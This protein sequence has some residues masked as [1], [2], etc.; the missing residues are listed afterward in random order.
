MFIIAILNW[1]YITKIKSLC[2]NNLEILFFIKFLK[3]NLKSQEY[4]TNCHY[5]KISS[6]DIRCCSYCNNRIS[7]NY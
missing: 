1:G 4:F 7:K 2:I 6:K 5:N 3:L